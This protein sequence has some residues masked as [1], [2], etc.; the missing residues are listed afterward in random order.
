MD[1]IK[2]RA[3]GGVILSDD[4]F[5]VSADI[6]GAGGGASVGVALLNR[7]G[8]VYI[9]TNAWKDLE[10]VITQVADLADAIATNFNSAIVGA[11]TS[12]SATTQT[13]TSAGTGATTITTKA[14]AVKTALNNLKKALR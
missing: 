4:G 3:S 9:P 5:S 11:V 2:A 7:D 14:T 12:G 1:I 13:V 6:V 10:T 8:G